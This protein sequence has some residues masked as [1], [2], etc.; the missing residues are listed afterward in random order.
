[1][2]EHVGT[3]GLAARQGGEEF[4][5]V[6]R[7]TRD[8]AFAL[9]ERIRAAVPEVVEGGRGPQTISFGIASSAPREEI[10]SVLLRQADVAL[11]EAKGAGRNRTIMA[12]AAAGAVE[13]VHP[14]R[15]SGRD[16]AAKS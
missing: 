12:A 2:R 16:A 1:M 10:L 9:A 11:Y 15:A 7:A 14:A 5:I 3:S 6:S 13:I 4:V 8:E